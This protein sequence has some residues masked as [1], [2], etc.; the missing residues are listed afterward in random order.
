MALFFF[1]VTIALMFLLPV[2]AAIALR[3]RY[4]VPWW[5]FCAGMA[6]FIG[7]QLI[8]LPLNKLL[9]EAGILPNLAESA[10]PAATALLLGFT[11]ALSETLT[12]VVCYW[13]IFRRR[14]AEHPQDGAMVGLGHGGVESFGLIA[15]LAGAQF[16]SLWLLR[17]DD[18]GQLGLSAPQLA[19][20]QQQMAIFSAPWLSLLAAVER[21]LALVLQVA[22][23]LLVWYGFRRRS[24]WPILIALLYHTL[25]DFTAAYLSVK[26]ISPWLVEGA[27][28]L[29]VIPGLLWSAR[30]W[31]NAP[32]APSRNARPIGSDLSSFAV[33]LQKELLLQWRSR[34][35]LVICAIFLLFGLG[36]PLLARFTPELLGMVEE[37]AQF[38]DLLPE[39]DTAEALAQY[40]GNITE[41]GFIIAVLMG[42]GAVAG[43]KE[44]GTVAMVLSKPLPRWAFLLSKFTAQALVYVLAFAVAS[45]GSYYYTNILFDDLQAGPF[46]LGNLLLCLWL[47]EFAAVTLLGSTLAGSTVAG[48]GLA[49][50]GGILLFILGGLPVVSNF[51][52]AG[53]VVW[54]S[55]LGLSGPATPNGGA[56]VAGFSLILA[57]L[58]TAV[59]VFEVQEL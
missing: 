24:V 9:A 44:Q 53:L 19:M 30:L 39:P 18:L 34:R 22:L 20:L 28:A 55:Q 32:A 37:A 8:H 31:R 3:R 59:A 25:I 23:S 21:G 5:L 41:F 56:L 57:L 4:A 47:L 51:A 29:L 36:S 17:G 46:L 16:T 27:L 45:L 49:L 54:A 38:A 52:P 11:A 40:V 14:Q 10:S 43:E 33:A 26:A 15:I 12:R 2:A 50:A 13:P 42:M 6:T 35:L 48:A 1:S 58:I 7:A